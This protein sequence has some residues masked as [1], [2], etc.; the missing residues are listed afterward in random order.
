MKSRKYGQTKNLTH[1]QIKQGISSLKYVKTALLFGSR[2]S[3]QIHPKSDYDFA[4]EMQKLPEEHWG[5]QARAWMDVCAIFGVK[6]YDV[7]I[8]DL[9]TADK[10]LKRAIAHNHILLKGD[11]ND[12]P[13]L[14][15]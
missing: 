12:I 10:Y 9:A 1:D 3:G 15:G 13:R 11:I 6:E 2:A 4:F 14:L 8:V 5:M 7:D